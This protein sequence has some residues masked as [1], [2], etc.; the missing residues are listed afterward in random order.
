MEFEFVEAIK[1]RLAPI[2]VNVSLEVKDQSY[3]LIF[4]S[5][6]FK[7]PAT[8]TRWGTVYLPFEEF[9]AIVVGRYFKPLKIEKKS[10]TCV[11]M[12]IGN[13]FDLVKSI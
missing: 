4:N 1:K 8:K 13:I 3:F 9:C 11:E 5:E 2:R 10:D 7:D 12:E 6:T